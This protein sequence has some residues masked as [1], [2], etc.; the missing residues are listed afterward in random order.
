MAQFKIL[1]QV[2]GSW[3]EQGKDLGGTTVMNQA[4]QLEKQGLNV[5]VFR[6][7]IPKFIYE[8]GAGYHGIWY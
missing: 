5:R 7:D 1:S 3:L 4:A 8:T 6:T 2:N